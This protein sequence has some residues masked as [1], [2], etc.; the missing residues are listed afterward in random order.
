[1]MTA[2]ADLLAS[3]AEDRVLKAGATA[4]DFALPSVD[5]TIVRLTE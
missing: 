1:M 4:P 2:D 5:G 3:G